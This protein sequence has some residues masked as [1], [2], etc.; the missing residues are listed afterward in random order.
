MNA[1]GDTTR[2]LCLTA[3]EEQ[4]AIRA[5]SGLTDTVP[6]ENELASGPTKEM[7][8]AGRGILGC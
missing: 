7:E 6:H 1:L 3:Q 4:Q 8:S 5:F 2:E